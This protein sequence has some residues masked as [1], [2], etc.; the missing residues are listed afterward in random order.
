MLLVAMPL[1]GWFLQLNKFQDHGNHKY[2]VRKHHNML[3]VVF[4][5]DPLHVL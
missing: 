1:N 4:I 5:V 2:C 3:E